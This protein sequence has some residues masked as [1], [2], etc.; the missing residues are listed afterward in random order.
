MSEFQRFREAAFALY[1]NMPDD[2]VLRASLRD[3]GMG[4]FHISE[5]ASGPCR[6][7]KAVA[8]IDAEGLSEADYTCLHT[9]VAGLGCSDRGWVPRQG[10][11]WFVPVERF[12]PAHAPQLCS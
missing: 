8:A 7:S 1:K 2:A 9:I 4:S 12:A 6:K 10:A 3:H 11:W 5:G